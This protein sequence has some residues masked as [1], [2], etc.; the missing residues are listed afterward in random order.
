MD[1]LLPFLL[2]II[3]AGMVVIRERHVRK[4]EAKLLEAVDHANNL[5]EVLMDGSTITKTSR[6][7]RDPVKFYIFD[8]L[9]IFGVGRILRRIL[10]DL[11]GKIP[12]ELMVKL[13][14][15]EI[16]RF[17]VDLLYDTTE[18]G[19]GT[20]LPVIT[21]SFLGETFNPLIIEHHASIMAYREIVE[22]SLIDSTDLSYGSLYNS[23]NTYV[24]AS[25]ATPVVTMVIS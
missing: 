16:A 18:L 2:L 22:L 5:V 13:A 11:D 8:Q 4:T 15:G 12:K 3:A 21:F 20:A 1:A 14:T 25:G 19:D 10:K 23:K 6:G 7:K 9:Y 24:I 17:S